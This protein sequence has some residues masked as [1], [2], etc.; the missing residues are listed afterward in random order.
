LRRRIAGVRRAQKRRQQQQPGLPWLA[1]LSRHGAA[2]FRRYIDQIV[3]Y[4]ARRAGR[5]IETKAELREQQQL[6]AH[7]A[8]PGAA[9]IDEAIE[10]PLERGMALRVRVALGQQTAERGEMGHAVE[11]VRDR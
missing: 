5:K 9:R 11:R 2:R 8:G 1:G 7:D 4:P 6:E 3:L 10:S